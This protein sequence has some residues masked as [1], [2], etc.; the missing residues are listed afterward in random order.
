MGPVILRFSFSAA[1]KQA[2]FALRLCKKCKHKTT[3]VDFR[4]GCF[5]IGLLN[6]ASYFLCYYTGDKRRHS[7]INQITRRTLS[8][9]TKSGASLRMAW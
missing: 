1:Y 3:G 6:R 2:I 7:S 8:G 5:V 4:T 9:V